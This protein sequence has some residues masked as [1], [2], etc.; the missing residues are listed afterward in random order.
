[1]AQPPDLDFIGDHTSVNDPDL[2]QDRLGKGITSIS[3]LPGIKTTK[4]IRFIRISI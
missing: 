3:E 4:N 1:M 2:I